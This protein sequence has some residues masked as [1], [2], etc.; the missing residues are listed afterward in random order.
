MKNIFFNLL[1]YAISFFFNFSV[2]SADMTEFCNEEEQDF[3]SSSLTV[4]SENENQRFFLPSDHWLRA[5]LDDIFIKYPAALDNQKAF[6]KAGFITLYRQHNSMMVAKHPSLPGYLVKVYLIADHKS[7][8]QTL[9]RFTDRCKGAENIRLLIK[10]EKLR[11]FTVPD[12]WLYTYPEELGVT[13]LVVTDANLVT[14]EESDNAWK[15]KI[16]RKH[17]K[18]LYTILSNG[19]ASCYLTYNIPYTK[20]GTFSCVDTAYANKRRHR[21]YHVKNYLSEK[22]KSY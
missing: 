12:K 14:R 2:L 10:K 3:F 19:F 22:M 7:K 11:Y 5:A 18:E 13:I 20:D 9:H 8:E 6:A 15:T 21:Y 4:D 17:L 1:F 16:T